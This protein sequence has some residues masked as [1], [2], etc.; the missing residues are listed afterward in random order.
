MTDGAGFDS[1]HADL[2]AATDPEA[3]YE[4]IRAAPGFGDFL[5]YQV[6]VDLL[7]PG[8]AHDGASMLPFPPYE[9]AAA[10]PGAQRGLSLI[11]GKTADVPGLDAMRWL[12]GQQTL[13]ID[14]LGIDVDSLLS[15]TGVLIP[16]SLADVQNASMSS[17][18]TSGSGRERGGSGGGSAPPGH[19]RPRSFGSATSRTRS[20]S[21]RRTTATDSR[22]VGYPSSPITSMSSASNSS[23]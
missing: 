16:L 12:W 6:L 17:P 22:S 1:V 8:P 2:Q 7:Y 18:S 4:T 20:R 5:A 3:A 11:L 9:W 23:S 13:E 19:G 10:G 21:S 15:E 14:R